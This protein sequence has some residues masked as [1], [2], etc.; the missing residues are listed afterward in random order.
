M[1]F[2]IKY[3]YSNTYQSLRTLGTPS[4]LATSN[5]LLI[6]CTNELADTT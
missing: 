1:Y 3:K 6:N 4:S 5:K 2:E